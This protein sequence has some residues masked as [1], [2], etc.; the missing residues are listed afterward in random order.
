MRHLRNCFLRGKRKETTWMKNVDSGGNVAEERR[1]LN[2]RGLHLHRAPRFL[3][4][5]W[6]SS[7]LMQ[8]CKAINITEPGAEG[9]RRPN[10]PSQLTGTRRNLSVTP[11]CPWRSSLLWSGDNVTGKEWTSLKEI[12]SDRSW[13]LPYCLIFTTC[14]L[15]PI[16]PAEEF[17]SVAI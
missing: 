1:S 4:P 2:H 14:L 5:T 10:H 11:H 6:P 16:G 8:R 15:C 13:R 12:L 7:L 3:P 17:L 9:N